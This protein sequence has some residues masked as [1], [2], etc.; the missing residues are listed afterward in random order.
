MDLRHLRYF[1]AVAEEG[2][3][4]RAAQRLHIVQSALSMQ[5][6]ALEE[7]L[8]GPLFLR[9]SRRVEL[10]EAGRL[11]LGE[12]ERTLAQAEHAQRTVQRAIRG[13]M[14]TVRIG[15][16]GN[17]VFS[18]RLMRDVRA[19]NAAYPEAEVVLRELAPYH[20]VEAIQAG[21]LDVGY[22]PS[23]G[24]QIS[25]SALCF[26]SIGEWPLL[27]AMPDTHPLAST[28]P[29]R[30]SML[31]A[32]AL[33]VYAAHGADE[34]MLGGLRRALGREPKVHRT[35]STLSVLALVAAGMGVALV[36]EPLMQVRIPGVVYRH[37]D[38]L[39]QPADL[40]LVSRNGEGGGA[41]RAFLGIARQALAD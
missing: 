5:I 8:G 16:A 38:D 17:A 26:E 37:L 19:F 39:Q 32:E 1:L 15:F 23:H 35:S 22:A 3:F 20:Q 21:Q 33:I 41:V 2:H 28:D 40:L 4:G 13:E 12:A 34:F 36:P 25:D 18:G 9:T 31:G 10:T 30:V 27:V 24:G 7:E 11:L 29:L 6:R 14:G